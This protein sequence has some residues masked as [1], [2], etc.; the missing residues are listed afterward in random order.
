VKKEFTIYG[1]PRPQ[2]RARHVKNK[3]TEQYFVYSPKDNNKEAS[4]QL[5]IHK[6]KIPLFGAIKMTITFYLLRPKSIPIHKRRFPT[7]KPDLTNLERFFEDEMTKL[8]YYNDDA[9]ICEKH[10]RKLYADNQEPQTVII[11]EEMEANLF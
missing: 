8:G 6:P 4:K 2:Q 10:S 1:I 9:Y 11:L 5:L 3:R 7:P